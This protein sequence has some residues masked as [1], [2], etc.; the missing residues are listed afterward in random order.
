MGSNQEFI[1]LYFQPNLLWTLHR[2]YCINIYVLLINPIRLKALYYEETRPGWAPSLH[3]GGALEQES[4][5]QS[6]DP[7]LRQSRGPVH[8]S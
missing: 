1:I 5:V 6:V 7:I 3:L 8:H 2:R 4:A